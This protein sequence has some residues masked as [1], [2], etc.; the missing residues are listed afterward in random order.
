M[1]QESKVQNGMIEGLDP[2][3]LKDPKIVVIGCGGAGG[4]SVDRL[5][6]MGIPGAET[7]ALNTDK[8]SLDRVR[9]HRKLL[10]GPQLARGRGTGGDDALGARCAEDQEGEIAQ[11]VAEADIAFITLGLGGGTGTG[12]A[13]VVARIANK[14][15]ALVVCM[16]SLPFQIERARQRTAE[17]GLIRLRE[18]THSLIVMENER[19]LRIV[20]HLPLEHAFSV[21]DHVI[22]KT[23]LNVSET[24]LLPSLINLDLSDFRTLM[25]SAGTST[26]LL[27]DGPASQPLAVV[28]E[29]LA[30]PLLEIDS[31]RARGALIH[32]TGGPEMSLHSMMSVVGGITETLPEGANVKFGARVQEDSRGIIQVLSILT[33]VE[34]TRSN[35]PLTS[36]PEP[37]PYPLS[38]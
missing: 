10:L 19:L 3:V 14:A 16:A 15:G 35:R 25:R 34:P 21:M 2:T 24:L 20:G 9:A 12:A 30:N 8:V 38:R 18:N 11:I 29:V 5:H 22:S 27:G 28:R 7:L 6:Q 26:I 1:G 31:S 4:N 37:R 23:I 36:L 32:I 13:P 33:G 17:E